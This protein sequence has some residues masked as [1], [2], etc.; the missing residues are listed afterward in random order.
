MNKHT[1]EDAIAIANKNG[2]KCLST[3]YV[4]V[5]ELMLWECKNNHQW[6]AALHEILAGTWCKKCQYKHTIEEMRSIAESRNGLCL[7]DKYASFNLPLKWRCNIHGYEWLAT[8]K[9]VISGTWC[10]ECGKEARRGYTIEQIN[11][12]S[13]SY[14]IICISEKYKNTESPLL[15]KCDQGHEFKETLEGIK[16]SNWHCPLCNIWLREEYCRQF[17]EAIFDVKF[18]HV[19]RTRSPEWLKNDKGNKLELDGYNSDLGIAFEHNGIQHYKAIGMFGNTEAL[20][21]LQENDKKKKDLCKSYNV[22]LIVIPYT[23]KINEMNNFIVNEYNKV[24]DKKIEQTQ[25][26]DYKKF[27]IRVKKMEQ[28]QSIAKER[29]GEFLSTQYQG[30]KSRGTWKCNACGNEWNAIICDVIGTKNR[31]G[32][33]C[34]NCAKLNSIKNLKQICLNEI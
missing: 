25:S 7:S 19:S 13:S 12:I 3:S 9:T 14:G 34:P 11:R 23:V 21:N 27:K 18:N 20:N 24:S 5:H 26:I 16:K 1:I 2:G 32:T 15:W 30:M 17:F 29:N 4:N 6:K 10:F 31:K 8:P 28:I 22:I 33:W